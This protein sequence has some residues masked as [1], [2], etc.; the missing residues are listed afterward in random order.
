MI[1]DWG[2]WIKHDGK[3]CPCVGQFVH[4]EYRWTTANWKGYS[5]TVRSGNF[6]WGRASGG[7]CWY[8]YWQ[9]GYNHVIRY[10]IRRPAALQTLIEIAANPAPLPEEVEA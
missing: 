1:E 5:D 3:G 2:P 9:P 7:P 6:A 4:A 8:W 10:R